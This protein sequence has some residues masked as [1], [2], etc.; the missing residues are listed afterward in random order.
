[1]LRRPGHTEAAVDLARIAGLQPAGA[2]CEIVS[3]KDEG[4]MA[5]DLTSCGCS[6]TNTIWR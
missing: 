4:E 2:I 6:P 1:M 5:S 3:Q